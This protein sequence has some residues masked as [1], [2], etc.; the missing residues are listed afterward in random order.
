MHSAPLADPWRIADPAT[1]QPTREFFII[2]DLLFDGLDRKCEPQNTGILEASKILQTW[3]MQGF[4]DQA[5]ELF[6]YESFSA[7]ALLWTL[8]GVPHFMVPS[9]PS[10]TPSWTVETNHQALKIAPELPAPDI[11]YPSYIP[12][13]N[14]AG[15]YK[16]LFLELVGEPELLEKMMP[17]FCSDTYKPNSPHHPDLAR[18]E[19][20]SDSH[21][22]VRAKHI[23]SGA[24]GRVCEKVAAAMQ[25]SHG[26][27][28]NEELLQ[29][30]ALAQIQQDAALKMQALQV[31]QQMSNMVNQSIVQGG[32]SFSMA[33][34]NTYVER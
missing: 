30:Q 14:R 4:D 3:N 8:Q 34:G 33:A 27:G 32:Q 24:V 17:L 21:L 2:A 1:E 20:N 28:Q 25:Q 6:R 29:Q 7:F 23:G 31:Q 10:L 22:S 19:K 15:W 13:L 16:F 12:A 5:A 26:G 11:S 18:L 9:Q